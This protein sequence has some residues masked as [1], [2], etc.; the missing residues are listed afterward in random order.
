MLH[1]P[2][3]GVDVRGPQPG[4]EQVVAAEDVQRQVAV[5]LV[6]AVEEAAELVAVDRVVG[7]VEVEHDPLGRP[8]VGLEE[9]GHEEAFDVAGAAGD[10]LVAA[11]RVGADG[12]QFEAVEGALAGQ[13]LAPIAPPSP[14]LAGGVVLADDGGQQAGRGGGRRGR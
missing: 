1:R 11:V 7:G 6:V 10:L 8:G 9:E 5:A 13:R 4:A 14:G 3:A 2:G 12:G